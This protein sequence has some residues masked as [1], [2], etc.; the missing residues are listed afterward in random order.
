MENLT[1]APT[2]IELITKL[3]SQTIFTPFLFLVVVILIYIFLPKAKRESV[4]NELIKLIR[5]IKDRGKTEP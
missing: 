3:L 2:T 1:D 4:N 5:A